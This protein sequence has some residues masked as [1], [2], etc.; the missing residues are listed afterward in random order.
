MSILHFSHTFLIIRMSDA[1]F[2]LSIGK[3]AFSRILWRPLANFRLKT[4]NFLMC[5]PN[6][7]PIF[8]E[9]EPLRYKVTWNF[10]LFMFVAREICPFRV[11]KC[12]AV[13]FVKC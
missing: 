9:N 5:A 6:A 12:V 10:W 4:P 11:A 3:I 13:Q 8:Y 1:L 2:F 7:R